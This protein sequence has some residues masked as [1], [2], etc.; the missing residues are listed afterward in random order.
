MINELADIMYK[1]SQGSFNNCS[2]AFQTPQKD[3]F[4]ALAVQVVM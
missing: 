1:I 3:F 2:A 4:N